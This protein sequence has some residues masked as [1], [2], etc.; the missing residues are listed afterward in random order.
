VQPQ[1]GKDDDERQESKEACSFS[2][3]TVLQ[4]RE[5]AVRVFLAAEG[6]KA[7]GDSVE[8]GVR[9]RARS[10]S[11]LLTMAE[12]ASTSPLRAVAYPASERTFDIVPVFAWTLFSA[13]VP[14][15]RAA[16]VPSTPAMGSA[17]IHG[18]FPEASY[19]RVRTA[20]SA[21]GASTSRRDSPE[22]STS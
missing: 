13:V 2:H 11:K 8:R 19:I 21:S 4:K 7:N 22:P 1:A 9:L 6:R 3:E 14:F 17:R 16:S 18:E 10:P 20:S 12:N 5:T 15:I